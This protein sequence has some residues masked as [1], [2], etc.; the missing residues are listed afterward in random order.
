MCALSYHHG[1][2][3]YFKLASVAQHIKWP[4]NLL[5]QTKKIFVILALQ[6]IVLRNKEKFVSHEK[7]SYKPYIITMTRQKS[8]A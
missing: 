7:D 5:Y 2:Y 4:Q 1:L 6:I 3:E 8:K